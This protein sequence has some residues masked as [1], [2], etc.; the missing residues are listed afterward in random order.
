MHRLGLLAPQWL[1]NKPIP[2][3]AGGILGAWRIVN[4]NAA[5]QHWLSGAPESQRDALIPV[6]TFDAWVANTLSYE[7]DQT[8]RTQTSFKSCNGPI[9]DIRQYWTAN[10]PW[11]DPADIEVPVMLIHGEWD[12]DVPIDLAQAWFLRATGS[13]EKRWLEI[14]EAT[15]MLILEKNHLQVVNALVDFFAHPTLVTPD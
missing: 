2:I 8:L 4:M 6:G 5:R 13:P 7:P 11:Y 3:D 10:N 15:H 12:I 14:G 9:Q 1:S